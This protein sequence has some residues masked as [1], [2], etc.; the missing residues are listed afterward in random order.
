[1]HLIY[2]AL[3]N[4]PVPSSLPPSL[5]PASKRKKSLPGSV[6]VLPASV[7]ARASPTPSIGSV[8]STDSSHHMVIT[9]CILD[10]QK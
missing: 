9:L 8:S 2:K 6:P 3:E 7:Q 5:L 4:F 10:L 1:M